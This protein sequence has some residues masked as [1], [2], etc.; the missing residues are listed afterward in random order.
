M[1]LPVLAVLLPTLSRE[2]QR[3]GD[4]AERD[5]LVLKLIKTSLGQRLAL[6]DTVHRDSMTR[7]CDVQTPIPS[8]SD[9]WWLGI[10]G[11][12]PTTTDNFNPALDIAR[13]VDLPGTPSPLPLLGHVLN[14]DRVPVEATVSGQFN[15]FRP[16]ATS[17][18]RPA[19]AANLAIVDDD[20]LG[21]WRHDG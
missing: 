5:L 7:A 12:V 15:A 13:Q 8:S 2:C 11:V 16:A 1:I 3:D 17:R 19:L 18:V 10:Q 9:I 6:V 20:L 21:P 14:R 4:G